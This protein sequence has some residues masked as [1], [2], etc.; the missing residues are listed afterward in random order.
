MFFFISTSLGKVF[1]L[2]TTGR[3]GVLH[4]RKITIQPDSFY[5]FIVP[6]TFIFGKLN[7]GQKIPMRS[8]K[9]IALGVFLTFSVFCAVLYT[10][11][12]KDACKGVTCLN[13]G[14]CSGGICTCPTGIGGTNCEKVYRKLY[15]YTYKGTS[16][17]STPTYNIT[18]ADSNNTLVFSAPNDTNYT[19]MQMVWNNPGMPPIT[20]PVIITNS[21]ANGSNFTIVQT[22][23]DTF[24]YNGTGSVNGTT[25]SASITKVRPNGV[26]TLVVINDFNKQ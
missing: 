7:N 22:P 2:A 23:V 20:L 3:S 6:K 4:N 16:T 17:Y 14:T 21:S 1:K 11:C 9:H 19:K 5:F 15:A 26:K 10:S 12:T 13:K 18:G 24:T 8:I 25:A